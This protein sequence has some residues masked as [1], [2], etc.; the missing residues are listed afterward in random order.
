MWD[1]SEIQQDFLSAVLDKCLQPATLLKLPSA[2]A[3]VF[4]NNVTTDLTSGQYPGLRTAGYR[5]GP[6]E[7][8]EIFHYALYRGHV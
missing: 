4:L 5:H 8:C 2:L 3:Q 1:A 6:G 7:R